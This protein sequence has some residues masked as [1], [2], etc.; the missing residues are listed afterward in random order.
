M[1]KP[2]AYYFSGYQSSSRHSPKFHY[3]QQH[4]Q[5]Q[6][7]ILPLDYPDSYDPA[8]CLPYFRAQIDQQ[9]A[10]IFIGSSLGGFW[11]L[12]LANHYQG[13]AILLN[14]CCRPSRFSDQFPQ[15]QTIFTA[16][17]KLEKV[18]LQPELPRLAILAADDQVLNAY[19]TRQ[20]LPKST[21]IIMYQAGG[22]LLHQNMPLITADIKRFLQTL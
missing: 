21:Q 3:L 2:L 18:P 1:K 9:P 13:A 5:A 7:H 6:A 15:Q 12:L 11:A 10:R 8:V 20:L 22:H 17:A 16:F 14:P 19:E 4:L